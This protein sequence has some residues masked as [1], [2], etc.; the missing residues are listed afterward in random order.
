[1]NLLLGNTGPIFTAIKHDLT[2]TSM[3]HIQS[4][5]Q[6]SSESW[7]LPHGPCWMRMD[8]I[9][10]FTYFSISHGIKSTHLLLHGAWINKSH[11]VYGKVTNHVFHFTS[12]SNLK[13]QR[14]ENLGIHWGLRH[15]G[16]GGDEWAFS[17][18]LVPC[19]QQPDFSIGF[20]QHV[21][22]HIGNTLRRWVRFNH[23]SWGEKHGVGKRI[24]SRGLCLLRARGKNPGFGRGTQAQSLHLPCLVRL[25]ASSFNSIN[26]LSVISKISIVRPI[27][28][29][30]CESLWSTAFSPMLGV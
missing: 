16:P 6:K 1:M 23:T 11:Q 21:H 9:G 10:V 28:P 12:L 13:A 3:D 19:W 25:W 4:A 18:K 26:F 30:C 14:T 8:G 29:D 27:S 7:R 20:Y 5:H 17:M 22:R 24:H 15:G 2:H